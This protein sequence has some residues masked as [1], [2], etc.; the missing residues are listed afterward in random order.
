MTELPRN[1]KVQEVCERLNISRGSVYKLIRKGRLTAKRLD[2]DLRSV[3]IPAE[4][5]V[6]LEE[7]LRA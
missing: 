3:R 1:M 6:A 7:A 2:G 4:Q 5:V